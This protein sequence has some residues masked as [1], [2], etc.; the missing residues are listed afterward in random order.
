MQ[1]GA[2]TRKIT[3]AGR[4]NYFKA[5][6][7]NCRCPWKE[8]PNPAHKRGWFSAHPSPWGQKFVRFAII[9]G[10]QNDHQEPDVSQ[11]CPF[12]DEEA[13]QESYPSAACW[14]PSL[15]DRTDP[16]PSTIIFTRTSRGQSPSPQS[17]TPAGC[18]DT[19][20]TSCYA[21]ST[22]ARHCTPWQR[23]SY[24]QHGAAC[25]SLDLGSSHTDASPV[26]LTHTLQEEGT[27]GSS[28][29]HRA[30]NVHTLQCNSWICQ[31]AQPWQVPCCPAPFRPRSKLRNATTQ[32]LSANAL[33]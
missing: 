3:H 21:A 26:L 2:M 28:R 6:A 1:L 18:R 11:L 8:G 32:G 25:Q 4:W 7:G 27:A 10:L 16:A 13:T 12:R 33:L 22:K 14:L 23:G 9:A 17:Q 20:F 19:H 24:H 5:C 15:Q 29:H 30:P 31:P